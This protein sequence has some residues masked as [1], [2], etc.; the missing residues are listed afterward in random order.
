MCRF[1]LQGMWRCWRPGIKEEGS[2]SKTGE[3]V[4]KLPVAIRASHF[5]RNERRIQST[6]DREKKE[7]VFAEFMGSAYR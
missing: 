7:D 6:M 2:V 4:Q 5:L 3:P 1:C